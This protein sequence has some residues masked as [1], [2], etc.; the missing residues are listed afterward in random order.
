MIG[1]RYKGV[2]LE[3]GK[4]TK[5]T[6]NL[7]SPLF[8]DRVQ[9]VDHSYQ[10]RIPLS[11]R[12]KA[13]LEFPDLALPERPNGLS[14]DV[15]L[16]LWGNLYQLA[17]LT[18]GEADPAGHY[19][20][21]SLV[22]GAGKFGRQLESERLR[23]IDLGGDRQ[24]KGPSTT[25]VYEVNDPGSYPTLL[26][27]KLNGTVHNTSWDP[28]D[29]DF[30][31]V[32]EL[33]QVLN[34]AYTDLVAAAIPVSPARLQ[35]T[36]LTPGFPL[37]V[38]LTYNGQWNLISFEDEGTHMDTVGTA[39]IG[40]YPYTF[41]PVRNEDFYGE[42]TDHYL[43]YVN[44]FDP[45][46]GK[47]VRNDNTN[48][49]GSFYRTTA[50]PFPQLRY[51][52]DQIWLSQG[53]TN[54]STFTASDPFVR[55]H[56]WNNVSLDEKDPV[57]EVNVFKS[58]FDLKNHVPDLSP[59][60]L[61]RETVRLFNLATEIN[62][63]DHQVDIYLKTDA[64]GSD[65]V[66]WRAK[67]IRPYQVIHPDQSAG[68]S[69]RYEQDG[70]DSYW[71]K[72]SVYG[73]KIVSGAGKNELASKLPPLFFDTAQDPTNQEY[74][75][76]PRIDQ[77]GG[78]DL[79]DIGENEFNARLFFFHGMQPNAMAND[80]PLGS[81]VDH[82]YSLTPLIP[83]TL[84]WGNSTGL[85][86]TYHKPWND[87]IDNARHGRFRFLLNAVDLLRLNWRQRHRVV[88]QEGEATVLHKKIQ[89]VLTMEGIESASAE[90][91]FV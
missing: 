8:A 88:V 79:F 18:L 7:V 60:E 40:A 83:N 70:L 28:G 72:S 32:D 35:I 24:L 9:W 12:N 43:G 64:L 3:L 31:A 75:R 44:L 19:V 51:V 23:K 67:T 77:G 14:F 10:F 41:C 33:A 15:E 68:H 34:G 11:R 21:G 39:A 13:I 46:K 80:Y 4:K 1:I 36:I 73:G 45:V 6:L 57:S 52:I 74:W 56:L 62:S 26:E 29:S 16:L 54:V 82:G 69:Y 59:A 66:D 76:T 63:L 5:L 86:E 17:T 91:V 61:F 47:F 30:D 27:I 87:V 25:G 71:N 90:S 38:D 37:D 42:A 81:P 49:L 22:F 65:Q 53:L 89:I 2:L 78:T 55:L 84:K 85:Y 58:T 20:N 50:V 48:P